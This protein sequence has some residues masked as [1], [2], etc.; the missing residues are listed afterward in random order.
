MLYFFGQR[1]LRTI[2][3]KSIAIFSTLSFFYHF[4]F[5]FV[6]VLKKNTIF[7]FTKTIFCFF[8]FIKSVLYL[9]EIFVALALLFKWPKHYY[10]RYLNHDAIFCDNAKMLNS[11]KQFRSAVNIKKR[12]M[13]N[14]STSA[15]KAVKKL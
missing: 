9:N 6:L 1:Q 11:T 5:C 14:D 4:F 10:W 8:S 7:L 2:S 13:K 12:V 15:L 3:N